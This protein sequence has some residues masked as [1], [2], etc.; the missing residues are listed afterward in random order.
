MNQDG[1]VNVVDVGDIVRFVV[2]MPRDRFVELLADL[3]NSGDVNVADAV[4][5]VNEIAGDTQFARQ[6]RAP[7]QA[8]NSVLTLY[9]VDDTQLSL[10][11]DSS[12]RY[13][14]FQFDLWLPLDVDIMQLRLNNDRCQGT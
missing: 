10:Q 14:A 12:E 6:L 3:N 9:S 11:L 5:L 1:T 13:A 7:E 4:V 8:G 2:G